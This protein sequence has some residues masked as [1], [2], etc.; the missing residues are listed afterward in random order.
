[1][2]SSP[3]TAP[4]KNAAPG[5]RNNTSGS[6]FTI[7]LVAR[8]QSSPLSSGLEPEVGGDVMKGA[9]SGRVSFAA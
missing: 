3:R 9:S 5:H 2:L 1:V 8:N 7:G 4:R 6:H